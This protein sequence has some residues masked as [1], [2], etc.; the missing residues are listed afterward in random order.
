MPS[1]WYPTCMCSVTQLC[2]HLCNPMDCSPPGSSVHGIL[3]A[4]I[5][6]WIAIAFSRGS[7]LH[8]YGLFILRVSG[9][10]F[11]FLNRPEGSLMNK[12]IRNLRSRDWVSQDP[13]TSIP[14]DLDK[15]FDLPDT[16]FIHHNNEDMILSSQSKPDYFS[17]DWRERSIWDWLATSPKTSYKS[18]DW[19]EA[20]KL[21]SRLFLAL[22]H[23]W[24]FLAYIS[25]W[26]EWTQNKL[27]A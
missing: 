8:V 9:F 10:F 18:E 13:V 20:V 1:P 26:K 27:L 3:Q 5:L 19:W 11:F 7:S 2:L 25:P 4:R 14:G 15:S 24:E 17:G 22:S 23:L 6:E 21:G 12:D 16:D